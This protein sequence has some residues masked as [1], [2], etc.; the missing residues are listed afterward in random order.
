M[1]AGKI[2]KKEIEQLLPPIEPGISTEEIQ[3]LLSFT[4]TLRAI[5]YVTKELID[6]GRARFYT[7]VRE[8]GTS[9]PQLRLYV[10]RETSAAQSANS[11]TTP[12]ADA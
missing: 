5:R 9:G 2:L 1:P 4:V 8:P 11:E 10:K 7:Q 6:V 3:K 12:K